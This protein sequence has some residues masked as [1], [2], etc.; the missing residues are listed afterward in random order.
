VGAAATGMNEEAKT[1]STEEKAM[2]PIEAFGAARPLSPDQ[3]IIEPDT[4]AVG[5]SEEDGSL[6]MLLLAEQDEN[7]LFRIKRN[8]LVMLEQAIAQALRD[9]G[10]RVPEGF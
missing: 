6:F 7:H 4:A 1:A 9:T 5:P 2:K 10:G 8:D 3:P